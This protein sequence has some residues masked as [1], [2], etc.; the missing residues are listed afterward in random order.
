[1]EVRRAGSALRACRRGGLELWS[2]VCYVLCMLEVVEGRLYLLEVL[3]SAGS[4]APSASL[5]AGGGGGCALFAGS[6][7]SA[8]GDRGD[9]GDRGAGRAFF[10]LSGR[11]RG[12]R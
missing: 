9:G 7:G 3:R 4:D 8:G 1:M 2:S 6:A 10:E 5:Y 11:S 12:K